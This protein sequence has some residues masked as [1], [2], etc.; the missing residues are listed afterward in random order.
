[1]V[2]LA[3]RPA[4]ETSAAEPSAFPS[5]TA[6]AGPARSGHGERRGREALDIL[7][8]VAVGMATWRTVW[9]D[10][11]AALLPSVTGSGPSGGVRLAREVVDRTVRQW[12]RA[13]MRAAAELTTHARRGRGWHRWPCRCASRRRTRAN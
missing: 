12:E 11:E 13:E 5:W 7:G 10:L 2:L 8:D 1:M 3:G 6:P 4:T 9:D